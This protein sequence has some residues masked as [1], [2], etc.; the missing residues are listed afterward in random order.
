M[1]MLSGTKHTPVLWHFLISA[2]VIKDYTNTLLLK[3]ALGPHARTNGDFTFKLA[4]NHLVML[5]MLSTNVL[6]G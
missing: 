2:P 1:V 4:G 3:L 6:E 5:L